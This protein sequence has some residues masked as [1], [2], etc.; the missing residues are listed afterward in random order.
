ME[1]IT[2]REMLAWID[3]GVGLLALTWVVCIAAKIIEHVREEREYRRG[4]THGRR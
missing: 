3:I 1:T 4:P 2:T